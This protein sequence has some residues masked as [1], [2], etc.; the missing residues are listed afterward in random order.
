M[1]AGGRS[2]RSPPDPSF[3]SQELVANS[4]VAGLCKAGKVVGTQSVPTTLGPDRG[5]SPRLQKKEA[6]TPFLGTV[7]HLKRSF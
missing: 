3:A 6:G 2:R 4:S 1:G 5:H 7:F